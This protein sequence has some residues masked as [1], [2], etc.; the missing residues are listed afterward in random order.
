MAY[1]HVYANQDFFLIQPCVGLRR[2]RSNPA[3][4]S[5][6]LLPEAAPQDIGASVQDALS[7]YRKLSEDEIPSFFDVVAVER[8]YAAWTGSML[9]KFGYKTRRAMF[10]R[11]RHCLVQ[12]KA[13]ELSIQPTKHE[14]LEAWGGT[15]M[16]GEDVVVIEEGAAAEAIG[17]AVLMALERCQ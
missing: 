13:S 14:K 16:N 17:R 4:P 1:A 5:H 6:V 12:V 8:D 7:K 2:V 3:E 11:M 9:K 10:R 15:G